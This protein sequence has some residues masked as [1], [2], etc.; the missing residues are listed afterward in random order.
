ML[1]QG[2]NA[3]ELQPAIAAGKKLT[4]LESLRVL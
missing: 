4:G 2:D 1:Y 3:A